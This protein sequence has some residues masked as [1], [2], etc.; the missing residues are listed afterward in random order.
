[1]STFNMQTGIG[2]II[3]DCA[4]VKR[5]INNI[6]HGAV[7]KKKKNILKFFE[8]IKFACHLNIPTTIRNIQK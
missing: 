3:N 6:S 1:M 8:M 5:L 7:H 2:N 4:C